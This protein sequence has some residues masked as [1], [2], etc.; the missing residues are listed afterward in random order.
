[1]YLTEGGINLLQ[2]E[3]MKQTNRRQL[4]KT[5]A[6]GT[7]IAL[8]A[9]S[10]SSVA[11][12]SDVST[13]QSVERSF[14]GTPSD[15]FVVIDGDNA[16][17]DGSLLGRIDY[18]GEGITTSAEIQGDVYSNNTW[19]STSVTLPDLTDLLLEIGVDTIIQQVDIPTLLQNVILDDLLDDLIEILKQLNPDQTQIDGIKTLAEELL[20]GTSLSDFTSFILPI[21]DSLLNDPKKSDINQLLG[22]LVDLEQVETVADLLSQLD[23]DGDGQPDITPEQIE[24][25]LLNLDFNSL[26]GPLGIQATVS[27][28]SGDFDPSQGLVTAPISDP[29]I[30]ISF[31]GQ[32]VTNLTLPLS[33]NLTTEQSGSMTGSA[34]GLESDSAS[35]TLVENEFTLGLDGIETL[36]KGIDFNSLLLDLLQSS[37]FSL[38]DLDL[39][40]LLQDIDPNDLIGNLDLSQILGWYITDESGRH[41][42]ELALDLEFGGGLPIPEPLRPELP[43]PPQDSDGDGLYENVRGESGDPTA[44]DVQELFNNLDNPEVQ[45]NSEVFN[46]QGNDPNKVSILDVQALFNR[47]P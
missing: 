28:I 5:T 3:T 15:G 45:N 36:I 18:A 24:Q 11:A 2:R 9:G 27:Q 13:S 40:S 43:G 35:V 38:G 32:E 17:G 34:S 22:L 39:Q 10:A 14:T 44:R 37:D 47:L 23:L 41:Y 8:G 33:V 6:A 31:E 16:Q 26:L 46:F 7:G 29:D 1:M 4:L 12:D 20:A 42:L 19:E 30:S 25:Q 21:L